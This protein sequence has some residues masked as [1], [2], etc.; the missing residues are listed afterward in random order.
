MPAR[1]LPVHSAATLTQA[2][3]WTVSALLGLDHARGA[4]CL[5]SLEILSSLPLC[6]L[7]LLLVVSDCSH[8]QLQLVLIS[9]PSLHWLALAR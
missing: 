3:S 5:I 1:T 7:Q 9:T 4:S 2:R 8:I 6:T